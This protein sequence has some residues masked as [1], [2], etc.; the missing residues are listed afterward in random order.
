MYLLLIKIQL[1]SM[2]YLLMGDFTIHLHIKSLSNEKKQF[3]SY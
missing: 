3:C 2:L 1:N